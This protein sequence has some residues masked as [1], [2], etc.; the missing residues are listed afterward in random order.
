MK[1]RT[2]IAGAALTSLVV[3]GTYFRIN[4]STE[5]PA[6]AT[7]GVSRGDVVETVEATGTVQPV[8][9]V[10]VG[11]QVTGTIQTL[12]AD[13]NDRVEAGHVLARLDPA[14]LQ[15]QVD[16]AAATV[17]RLS[18]EVN[19]AQ[20][21][22]TD[23]QTK[24]ARA[25]ALSAEQ[26]ISQA[27]LDAA[28]AARDLAQAA[29]V[30]ARAQLA[31]GR[32]SLDQARVNL[33][34]TI[35]RAPSA[36]VVLAR[37]VEVGQTVTSGL[38]TPT[39]FVIARDLQQMQVQASVDEADIGRVA[40]GQ[41]VTFTVD[42]HGARR[43]DGR[44]AQVRLQPVVAQNVVSYTT[45]ID[46]ANPDLALKPG[47]TAT[48]RIETGRADGTLRVPMAAVR[49]RPSADVL[50]A[51]EHPAES[52]VG[53]RATGAGRR[54]AA[55]R[56]QSRGAV[57]TLADGR[58]VRVPVTVGVSDGAFVAVESDRLAPDAVV[59]TGTAVAQAAS[60]STAAGSGSPLVPPAPR[61]GRR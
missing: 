16:Q 56:G 33:G 18:A 59:V 3:A 20:V 9:L 7:A 1:P 51:M 13:F 49:F 38:Q 4:A 12:G 25:E 46:V 37:N 23:A 36:G 30:S 10:E 41:P 21:T 22:L 47:M 43:F 57:W 15:A 2:W 5:Q 17:T 26:L 42:A 45:M 44:V 39:L 52:T 19:R 14:S 61:R 28:R 35:I 31:Q 60:A 11:A 29:V 8:D 53:N 58:L 6:L 54:E 50:Q 34:H 55:G 27:D 48:V 24:L 40:A 32:A